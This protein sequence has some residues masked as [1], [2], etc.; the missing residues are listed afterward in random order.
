MEHYNSLDTGVK[1]ENNI[2][3]VR[4]FDDV[5][6]LGLY[7]RDAILIDGQEEKA[8]AVVAL[9]FNEIKE[10]KKKAVMIITSPRIRTKQTANMVIESLKKIDQKLK[11]LSIEEDDLRAIDQGKFILPEPYVKG[12]EFKGLAIADRIFFNEVHASEISGQ[13]NNYD[14]KYADPVLLD[15][16]NY[17]YPE[18]NKY[19]SQ[20]GEC[21][22]D[23]LI[24]LYS[25]VVRTSEKVYKLKRNIELVLVTHGQPAQ[26]FCDLKDVAKLIKTHAVDY[27]EGNLAQLCWECYKKR[28]PAEK[29]TGAVSMISVDELIDPQ[30]IE[31]LKKEIRFLRGGSQVEN[32]K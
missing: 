11:C 14:Y 28:D 20:S 32:S 3:L 5:D 31:L 7:G 19:F 9:L 27:K 21:Y 23:V 22:R 10:R 6:D 12:Q 24:R 4:H 18:L 1:A 25:L 29:V 16:G 17:R 15:T 13:P 30:L 26:I 8:D 2:T